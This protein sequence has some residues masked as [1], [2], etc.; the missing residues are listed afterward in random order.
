VAEKVNILDAIK[1]LEEERERLIEGAK[2]EALAKAQEAIS[3]LGRLGFEYELVERQDNRQAAEKGRGTGVKRP[4]KDKP[5][6]ICGFK[7]NPLHD[8]RAHRSQETKKPFTAAE[9]KDKK[10]ERV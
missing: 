3:D 7:T 8:A 4:M 9:L 5:C 6:S 2:S 1:K 10:F